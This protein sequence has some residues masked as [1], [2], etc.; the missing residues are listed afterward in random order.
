MVCGRWRQDTGPGEACGRDRDTAVQGL[1]Q[2]HVVVLGQD[3]G[4]RGHALAAELY[5]MRTRHLHA[6]HGAHQ[7]QD[8]AGPRVRPAAHPVVVHTRRQV[9]AHVEGVGGRDELGSARG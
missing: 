7:R 6:M 8:V 3:E 5:L 2:D 4:G 1:W 9:Q